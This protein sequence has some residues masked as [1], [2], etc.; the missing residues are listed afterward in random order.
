MPCWV[1]SNSVSHSPRAGA[2]EQVVNENEVDESKSELNDV[3]ATNRC[4]PCLAPVA[5]MGSRLSCRRERG[6]HPPVSHPLS[7][8]ADSRRTSESVG[9][10]LAER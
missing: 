5:V 3:K 8:V 1:G 9:R 10:H 7:A 6:G 4:M 2:G